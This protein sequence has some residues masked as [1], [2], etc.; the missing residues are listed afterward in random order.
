MNYIIKNSKVYRKGTLAHFMDKRAVSIEEPTVSD[1]PTTVNP[2]KFVH[3]NLIKNNSVIIKLKHSDIKNSTALLG[4]LKDVIPSEQY[5]FIY[6]DVNDLRETIRLNGIS[7]V[8]VYTAV[9][10]TTRTPVYI[11]ST[12][13]SSTLEEKCE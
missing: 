3:T 6:I 7:K 1:L 10:C 5:I 8:D 2:F 13:T 9:N 4:L 12:V 11:G